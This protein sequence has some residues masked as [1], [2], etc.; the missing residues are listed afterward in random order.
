MAIE[1]NYSMIRGD[2]ECLRV[3]C[4]NGFQEGDVVALQVRQSASDDEALVTKIVDTF[5]DGKALI[6]LLPEDT[7]CIDPGK[8]KYD[9][10]VHW[11]NGTVK[12]IVEKSD[13]VLREDVTRLDNRH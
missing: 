12:T 2:S 8:Y 7:A 11:A 4:D 3:S 1:F 13:F 9:I 5:D 6:N 10:E